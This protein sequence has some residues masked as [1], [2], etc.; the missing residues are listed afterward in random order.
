VVSQPGL[1]L[2]E[3]VQLLPQ[4]DHSLDHQPSQ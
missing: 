1:I 2:P 4:G 3:H